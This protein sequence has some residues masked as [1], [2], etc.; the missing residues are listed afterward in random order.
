MHDVFVGGANLDNSWNLTCPKGKVIDFNGAEFM[1]DGGNM[2][3]QA[4]LVRGVAV[5]RRS[6]VDVEAREGEDP[7]AFP[8]GDGGLDLGVPH[9]I[10]LVKRGRAVLGEGAVIVGTSDLVLGAVAALRKSF[11]AANMSA[12]ASFAALARFGMT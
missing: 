9:E 7:G 11:V 6:R 10:G 4:E 2:V 1:R 3:D 8:V 12:L 5:R